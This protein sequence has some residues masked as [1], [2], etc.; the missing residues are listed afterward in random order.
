M[1][2][3]I[4]VETI[5]QH[6]TAAEGYLELGMLDEAAAEIEEIDYSL[7]LAREVL[8]MRARIY[9]A[10]GAWRHLE[11]VAVHLVREWPQDARHWVWLAAAMRKGGDPAG[12]R[13]TLLRAFPE[14]RRSAAIHAEIA[15]CHCAVGELRRAR[16]RLG[17]AIALDRGIRLALLDDP[18]L[19]SVWM[20]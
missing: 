15:R 1:V 5:T 18:D 2:H 7:R 9:H 3:P 12:A 4:R 16:Q 6:L 19:A 14:Q 17:L 11:T 20:E 13:V 10:A 8:T